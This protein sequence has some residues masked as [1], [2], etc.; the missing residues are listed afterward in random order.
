MKGDRSAPSRRRGGKKKTAPSRR[1]QGGRKPL[2][3]AGWIFLGAM[4][5]LA[6]AV[7]V[8][9]LPGRE[10]GDEPPATAAPGPAGSAFT[11]QGTQAL[12]TKE[13]QGGRSVSIRGFECDYTPPSEITFGRLSTVD[14]SAVGGKVSENVRAAGWG[15]TTFSVTENGSLLL[16]ATSIPGLGGDDFQRQ[17]DFLKTDRPEQISRTFLDNSGLIPLLKEYGLTLSTQAENN[18]G[19][20]LFR[21]TGTLP[22]CTCSAR[23]T[24]LYTGAFD[25][26]VIRAVYLA[27]AVTTT[28]VTPLKKAAAQAVT[29]TAGTGDDVT[30]TAA[31][32]RHVSGLPFYAFTCSDGT[33][34]FALAVS[35]DALTAVPGAAETYARLLS[36]G[37]EN[38]V[39]L[40]GGE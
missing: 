36:D 3:L 38:N 30:V 27:D 24:F 9:L 35:Q 17:S 26:A 37:I 8:R 31:E 10:S 6:A 29:W 19:E 22:G 2:L 32:L 11:S 39:T 15:E 40:S 14:L 34:A 1:R 13:G 20:I 21:G 25:Q 5:L 12:S 23:F 18:N 33:T 7:L 16:R 28:D 4:I